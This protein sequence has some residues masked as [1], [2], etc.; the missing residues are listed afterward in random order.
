MSK[1]MKKCLISTLSI[2]LV[3]TVICVAGSAQEPEKVKTGN[4]PVA[5]PAQVPKKL[6]Y[7]GYLIDSSGNPVNGSKSMTFSIYNV[8]T[9]GSPLWTET[10]TVQVNN[11]KYSVLLGSTTPINLEGPK[12]YYLGVKVGTDAEMTPREEL[13]SAMYALFVDGVTMKGSDTRVGREGYVPVSTDPGN[14]NTF[15]GRAAGDANP[16]G[17]MTGDKNTFIGA[18]AG[19]LNTTGDDNTFIGTSAGQDNTTGSE[20]TFIGQDAGHENTTGWFN[21]FIGE[22]AGYNISTGKWNTFI[23]GLAGHEGTTDIYNTFIGFQAGRSAKGSHN[24]Y[25]GASAGNSNVGN[26]NVFIGSGAGPS[27]RNVSNRLYINGKSRVPLIYGEFDNYFVAINGN[28]QIRDKNDSKI[29][30]EMGE[31]LDYAEGFDIAGSITV[32]PGTVLVID[33]DNPGKLAISK[34]SYDTKVAGIVAGANGMGSGVRLG[35]DQ[36]DYD[37]A[38]AGRVYCNVDATYG[39]VSPG[40]LLTTSPTPGYAMVVDDYAKAQGA[41][42]GKAMESLEKSK[43]GQILVLV[44]LQ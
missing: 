19:Q 32:K 23:G 9:G 36:F 30:I 25:I 28:L 22:G 7:Q 31:G 26:Y 40:D 34:S 42:L 35:A 14:E 5:G 4:I 37:V 24:T 33:P 21:T 20:N 29:F 44:T 41:I 10:Q 17:R 39:E 12:L 6:N 11:G 2:L 8:A 16:P 3:C 13:T 43:K 1:K 27:G 38:L 15:I 18:Y